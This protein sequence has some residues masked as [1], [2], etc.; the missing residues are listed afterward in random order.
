M[1][2]MEVWGGECKLTSGPEGSEE[3]EEKSQ[4][5]REEGG[6]GETEGT[7]G[8]TANTGQAQGETNTQKCQQ[9]IFKKHFSD[10]LQYGLQPST[11]DTSF[12]H[13]ITR[14]AQ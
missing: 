7:K 12:F 5:E 8:E 14:A 11:Y 6:E 10:S 1:K 3:Q 9:N 4:K 2:Q 13:S